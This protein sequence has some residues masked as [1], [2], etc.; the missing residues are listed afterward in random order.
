[1][2]MGFLRRPLGSQDPTLPRAVSDALNASADDLRHDR[3]EDASTFLDRVQA[4][5]GAYKAGRAKGPGVA[6]KP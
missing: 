2:T 3:V 4:K 5:V 1:M 6:M